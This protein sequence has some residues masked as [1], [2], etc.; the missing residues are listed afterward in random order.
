MIFGQAGEPTRDSPAKLLG[1]APLVI[2]YVLWV[3]V[4]GA[5]Y[6]WRYRRITL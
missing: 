1:N 6:L 5:I 3:A 2:W 4:P